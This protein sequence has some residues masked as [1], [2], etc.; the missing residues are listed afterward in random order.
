[1]RLSP[2]SIYT[3]KVWEIHKAQGT[4]PEVFYQNPISKIRYETLQDQ[5]IP[6][7]QEIYKHQKKELAAHFSPY[8]QNLQKIIAPINKDLKNNSILNYSINIDKILSDLNAFFNSKEEE[9]ISLANIR[10]QI[11]NNTLSIQKYE[12]YEQQLIT[13]YKKISSSNNTNFL[14]SPDF[15]DR[16]NKMI[17]YLSTMKRSFKGE[18]SFSDFLQ[19]GGLYSRG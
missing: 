2:E 17:Q 12:Q 13:L 15:K 6:N 8:K 4:A 14:N 7:N 16:V 11:K 9:A 19:N 10:T 1:M 3:R 5:N 18:G